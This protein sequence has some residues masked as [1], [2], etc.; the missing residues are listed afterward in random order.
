MSSGRTGRRIRYGVLTGVLVLATTASAVIAT[1]LGDRYAQRMD[2]TQT[3]EH[4]LSERTRR[5]VGSLEPGY[6]I[7]LAFDTRARDQYGALRVDQRAR[8]R[9]DDVLRE[10]QRLNG[11]LTITPIDTGTQEGYDRF[12]ELLGRLVERE[13]EAIEKHALTV[14]SSLE[15]L[16]ELSGQMVAGL[17]GRLASAASQVQ[18]KDAAT[19]QVYEYLN[20][21]SQ[22]VGVVGERAMN[23][24]DSALG[25]LEEHDGPIP[26]S[27]EL[28]RQA[29]KQ[30]RDLATNLDRLIEDLESLRG[31]DALSADVR[32]SLGELAR[33][34][35][36]MQDSALVQADQIDRLKT[37]DLHRIRKA[38]ASTEAV[39]VIGP[40][41]EGLTAIDFGAL[42][43]ATE[44]IDGTTGLK[45][46]LRRRAEELLTSALASLAAEEMPV[47]VFAHAA[48]IRIGDSPQAF[49]TAFERLELR[50]IDV[51]EWAVALD[52][53]LPSLGGRTGVFV[54]HD[55]E[56]LLGT[57]EDGLSGADRAEVLGRAMQTVADLG[58][59]M[60]ISSNPSVLPTSGQE[61]PTVGVLE[62][63]GLRARTAQTLV[64][65]DN[66]S[67]PANVSA[68]FER[69]LAS[70]SEHPISGSISG[71]PL[72][73]WAPVPLDRVE[74][75]PPHTDWWPLA[76]I[77]RDAPRGTVWSES[78]WLELYQTGAGRSLQ[79]S[80]RPTPSERRDD[81]EGPWTVIAAAE[82]DAPS[83]AMTKGS[84]QRLVYVG[85]NSWFHTQVL[86]QGQTIDGRVVASYPGNAELL[87]AAVYWLSGQDELI[88]RSPTAQSVA[89]V[90]PLSSSQL[91][92]IN[93]MLIGVLPA[94]VLALGVGW[95]LVRG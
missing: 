51:Q 80:R 37:L 43:P 86:V 56:S 63:F 71:L 42:F 29:A 52:P 12:Q 72:R 87:E 67:D 90:R 2:V 4:E 94:L 88:A 15:S 27:D 49:A 35:G 59:P 70:E 75:A 28:A 24:A 46:D 14:R 65:R 73:M 23:G 54:F 76:T 55:T 33:R 91:R 95:R 53:V 39:L 48:P 81:L 61:D 30:L 62:G 85:T 74:D 93:I 26:P 79:A 60:L 69:V 36:T 40:S 50:G 17:P 78:E 31:S 41:G 9:T 89:M 16:K 84:N 20:R 13:R 18:V 19:Q 25:V 22:L 68:L 34:V 83:T 66:A 1:M 3:G 38:L 8:Q 10:M 47:V 21:Q 6:E 64:W 5:L 44:V 92:T 11:G 32:A 77:E 45:A 7:V 57:G 82:R 58:L